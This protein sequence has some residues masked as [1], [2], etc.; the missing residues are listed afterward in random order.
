MKRVYTFNPRQKPGMDT[1]LIAQLKAV[2]IVAVIALI[3]DY[4]LLPAY[5]VHS[6]ETV[7]LFAVYLGLYV[8]FSFSFSGRFL[9]TS[10]LA[11]GGIGVLFAFT[12]IASFLGSEW[13]NAE[14]FRDQIVIES[15]PFTKDINLVTFDKVPLVDYETASQLGDKQLGKVQGLGSQ[16]NINADYTLVTAMD[17]LYRV[18]PL[19]YQDLYK[20]FQNRSTG[21]PGYVRVNVNDL[22]DV[23]LIELNQGIRYAPSAFFQEDLLRH[24][25][26]AY[27]TEI[28]SD[29]SFE[30]DESGHPYYVISVIEPKIGF[31]SGWDAVGVIVVDAVSGDMIKYGLD[32]I[33]A[34]IDRVQPT[35]LAWYQ[36]D[37]WGYYVNGFFNTL[38][39]R[40]DVIQTTDGFNFVVIDGQVHVYS[41][42]T[43][44]GADRSIVGFA[45]INLRTK[46]ATYYQVGGA[47][48]YSA[49]SSAQGQV[50]DLGYSATFPVLLN[51]EGEP[52]YF[53][54]LKDNEGLIKQYAM[55][56]VTDYSVVGVGNSVEAVKIVYRQRLVE[57]GILEAPEIT[58]TTLEVTITRIAS[59]IVGG[60]STY[61]LTVAEDPRLF[62]VDV[63]LSPEIVLSQVGDSVKL[64]IKTDVSGM[65]IA[66]LGFDNLAYDY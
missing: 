54:S 23:K 40:K 3:A 15:K 4:L 11:L 8:F 43:S 17:K 39:G 34:W 52:T 50:Q 20:W 66:V 47:D 1:P 14:K 41:G 25:R 12:L 18:S 57:A 16:Y 38:F 46:A 42:M 30:I 10:Q 45:L 64:T 32:D 28:L 61:Y 26:F 62:V 5:N 55:V 65:T 31:F 60:Q 48:E 49:M 58:T 2:G 6:L 27:R 9:R 13:L 56:S 51:F 63:N 24:V 36:V 53:M 44:V 33:P 35:D 29:F 7:F 37:N 59:A 22:N 21:I 19:E